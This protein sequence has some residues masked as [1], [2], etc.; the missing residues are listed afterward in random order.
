MD[1][2]QYSFSLDFKVR[3]Y[4]C[5]IQ[6]IVNNSVYQNYLE[7]ARHEFLISR[8][9]DFAALAQEGIHLVVTRVEL[10]YKSSLRSGNHF[11]V[12][13]TAARKGKVG[14]SFKQD[15]Y[16]ADGRLAVAAVVEGASLN[17]KGRPFHMPELDSLL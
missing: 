2:S 4:E 11:W 3:D 13:L 6:G 1:K 5:D 12:G 8:G 7:H 14:F 17:A 16:H 9:M 15:I 10:L